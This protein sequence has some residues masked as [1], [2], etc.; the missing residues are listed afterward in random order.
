[1]KIIPAQLGWRVVSVTTKTLSSMVADFTVRDVIAWRDDGEGCLLPVTV[2]PQIA[3][4]YCFA[5]VSPSGQIID[6]LDREYASID[7]Y[8]SHAA[9]ELLA[10]NVEDL[11]EKTRRSAHPLAM[12]TSRQL[13]S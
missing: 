12:A 11:A 9:E 1:M 3:R 6:W 8:V 2:S 10:C 13:S 4:N 5:A 7:D